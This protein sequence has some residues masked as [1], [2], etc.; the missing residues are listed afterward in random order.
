MGSLPTRRLNANMNCGFEFILRSLKYRLALAGVEITTSK[1][2]SSDF[3]DS[4]EDE[5][6]VMAMLELYPLRKAAAVRFVVS[7]T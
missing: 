5:E 4:K 7:S 1:C 2:V 6:I 3:V